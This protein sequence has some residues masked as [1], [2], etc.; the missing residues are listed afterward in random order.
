MH[1]VPFHVGDYEA[2][3]S[4]LT[5]VEDGIYLRLLRRYYTAEAPLPGDVLAVQRLV[6]AQAKDEKRAVVDMLQEFFHHG[7]DGW[8]HRRCD[9]E[10]AA[11]RDKQDRARASASARWKKSRCDAD[12]V[13]T[14]ADE[15]QPE[16]ANALPTQCEGNANQEPITN[17]QEP[18]L[19]A[20]ASGDISPA[21]VVASSDGQTK[22]KTGNRFPGEEQQQQLRRN[23]SVPAN[24]ADVAEAMFAEAGK[25]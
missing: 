21:V 3:T 20:F 6:R 2:A 5:A 19:E 24:A 17:S 10:I 1:Y 11:Y 9:A 15:A 12:A 14:H 25:P 16:D 7:P 4:H 13:P 8:R 22:S 18:R 23:G